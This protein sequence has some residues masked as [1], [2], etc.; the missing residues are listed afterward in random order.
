MINPLP[1]SSIPS[2]P[3][4]PNISNSFKYPISPAQNSAKNITPLSN[5]TFQILD[6]E[7][8]L[9][10]IQSSTPL[11]VDQYESKSLETPK[12]LQ[13]ITPISKGA[14]IT[15]NSSDSNLHHQPINKSPVTK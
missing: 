15:E 7:Y 10:P 14:Q 5:M 1:I 13:P 3:T 9:T 12:E 11:S 4:P 8:P 6:L 2:I